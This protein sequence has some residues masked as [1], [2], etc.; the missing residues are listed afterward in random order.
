MTVRVKTRWHKDKS[1]SVDEVAG[2]LAFNIWKIGMQALLE[3]ENEGFMTYSN[4]HRLQVQA[5][6]LAFM[7][8]ASD[9]LV[10][11]RLEQ[12][13][14]AEFV[15]ALALHLARAFA[16]NKRE[17]LG[18]GDYQG[19][20]IEH[21]NRRIEEYSELGFSGEEPH[22]DFLRHFGDCVREI[23]GDS[24]NK[25]WVNQYVIEIAAPQAMKTL[26]KTLNNLL[27]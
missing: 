21:L 24:Q 14:R 13:A 6:F 12:E 10:Y 22:M 15:T 18:A 8:Q 4:E 19:P 23:I 3:L 5:E 1:R 26:K 2:A 9:R 17:L 27:D 25:Y 11:A 7:L 16:D 20:F